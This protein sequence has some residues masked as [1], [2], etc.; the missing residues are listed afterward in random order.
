[1]MQDLIYPNMEEYRRFDENTRN[2]FVDRSTWK[3]L[4]LANAN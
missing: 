2:F 1:M 4:L 3:M